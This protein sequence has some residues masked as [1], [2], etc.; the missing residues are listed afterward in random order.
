MGEATETKK[1]SERAMK[2]ISANETNEQN[3]PDNI[4]G[5][6]GV[7]QAVW[8]PTPENASAQLSAAALAAQLALKYPR[9]VANFEKMPDGLISLQYVAALDTRWQKVAQGEIPA[10]H[11]SGGAD[12]TR[13]A[14]NK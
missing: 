12:C 6:P 9:T 7:A 2:T 4:S 13:P 11:Y 3:A 8:L 1:G 14:P 5:T 10:G